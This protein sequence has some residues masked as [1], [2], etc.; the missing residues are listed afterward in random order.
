MKYPVELIRSFCEQVWER[1]GLS[2]DDAKTCVDVLLTA[3][4]R[5]QRTHGTTHMRDYCERLR[6]GTASPGAELDIRQTSAT[7]FVVDANHA[8]GMVAG[9]KIM[10]SC[11]AQA[12][13]SGAC[14]ASVHNGCHYGIGAYYPMMASNETMIGVSFAN[15]PALVAPFGGADPLL[16]TNPVSV[17]IPAGRHPALVMDIAT[18]VVAKG[19]ISLALKEG[20]SIPEGWALDPD[21]APTT[22]PAR[23]NVGALLPFGAHKGYAMMLIGSLLSFALSGADMDRDLPRFFEEPERLS[24]VGYFMG[25]IDISKYCD[26]QAFLSR[27]DDMLDLMK[28]CRPAQGSGGVMIPG[29]IEANMTQKTLAEGI[30]LSEATLRDFQELAET[31][32]IPYIF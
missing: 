32:G 3:D 29:E 25:C 12:R 22:D 31:F 21:G 10:A 8:V 15:T 4:L 2:P 28:S 18:S 14:F 27:V 24:N 9:P 20:Q 6:L 26:P 13:H 16:G 17:A 5:G 11:I 23:A 7:S 1:A 30:D 19:R